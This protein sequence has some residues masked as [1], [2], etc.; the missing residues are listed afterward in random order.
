MT[1]VQTCALP[2]SL[3]VY[4][5]ADSANPV[6]LSVIDSRMSTYINQYDPDLLDS[7]N[8]S[9]DGIMPFGQDMWR[10][11]V[12]IGGVTQAYIDVSGNST[13]LPQLVTLPNA[14]GG[15]TGT[16]PPATGPTSAPTGTGASPQPTGTCGADPSTMTANQLAQCIQQFANA[17]NQLEQTPTPSSTG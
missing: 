15:G 5:L 10:G 8:S 1:G 9:L 2:I 16:A 4:V 11:F 7:D 14:G 12:D 6:S 13:V 17:L 3:S